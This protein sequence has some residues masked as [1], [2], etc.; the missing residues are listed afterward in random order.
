ME[1]LIEK[2][3]IVSSGCKCIGMIQDFLADFIKTFIVMIFQLKWK[4]VEVRMWS[5]GWIGEENL[6]LNP[7]ISAH[8]QFS[9]SC[10]KGPG[11]AFVPC[12][13]HLSS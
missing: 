4:I 6:S 7:L 11:E 8:K 5:W 10:S 1:K 9:E 2:Q 13:G 3:E 12:T